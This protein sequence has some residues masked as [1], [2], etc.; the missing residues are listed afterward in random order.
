MTIGFLVKQEL[1]DFIGFFTVK[2][3]INIFNIIVQC[4]RILLQYYKNNRD[5]DMKL[6][7]NLKMLKI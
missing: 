4:H 7:I 2:N 5:R 3:W 6:I 1:I